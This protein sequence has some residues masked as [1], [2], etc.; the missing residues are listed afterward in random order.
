MLDFEVKEAVDIINRMLDNLSLAVAGKVG[1]LGA[2]FRRAVGDLRVE[3][4]NFI[5]LAALGEPML[6]CFNLAREAGASIFL[7]EPVRI[8]LQNETPEALI[9]VAVTQAGILYTLSQEARIV[10]QIDFVSREDVDS[11]IAQFNAAFNSAEEYAADQKDIASYQ[12]LLALHASVTRF[13]VDRS[14]PLPRIVPYS[15]PNSMPSLA[16]ANRIYADASRSDELIAE[17]KVV[18]PLFAPGDG[19]A[20]SA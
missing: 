6:N 16:L 1:R 4:E 13:L 20:L 7:L 5:R 18:H 15:F 11:M 17:N 2:D 12:K 9:A 3:A 14:R 8:G 19:R 10:V